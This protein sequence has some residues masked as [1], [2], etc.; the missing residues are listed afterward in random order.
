MNLE[1][2]N[3]DVEVQ[4]ENLQV[5]VARLKEQLRMRAADSAK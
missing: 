5:E 4:N 3:D 1:A 2:R